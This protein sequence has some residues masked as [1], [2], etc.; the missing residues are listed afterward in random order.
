MR[1]TVTKWGNSLAL[2][3]PQPLQHKNEGEQQLG[4]IVCIHNGLRPYLFLGLHFLVER[5]PSLQDLLVAEGEQSDVLS[6]G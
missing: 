6:M 1:A 5:V 3:L 2:R 4:D